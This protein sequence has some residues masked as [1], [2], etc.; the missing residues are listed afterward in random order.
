MRKYPS[1]VFYK[2]LSASSLIEAGVRMNEWGDGMYDMFI[3]ELSHCDRIEG[4]VAVRIWGV[5]FPKD[6]ELYPC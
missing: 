4:N 5:E 6:R 1:A 2:E 3:T